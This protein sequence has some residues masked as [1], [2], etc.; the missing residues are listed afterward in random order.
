MHILGNMMAATKKLGPRLLHQSRGHDVCILHRVHKA[1]MCAYSIVYTYLAPTLA[2][3]RTRS[4]SRPA[5]SSLDM[6]KKKSI[7]SLSYPP[8]PQPLLL[9]DEGYTAATRCDE[10]T[11]T[12]FQINR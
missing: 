12:G 1:M 4:K 10:G 6:A 11:D 9:Q 2:S 8:P 7:P 5:K 3:R